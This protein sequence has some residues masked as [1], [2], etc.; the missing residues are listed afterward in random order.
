[1]KERAQ[2]TSRWRFLMPAVVLGLLGGH[3]L[4][5]MTAITLATGDR[6]FAVVPDYYQKAVDFDERKAALQASATLGWR[7]EVLPGQAVDAIGQREV[8]VILRGLDGEA[9]TEA[10]VSVSGYHFARASDPVAFTC[11]EVLPG[12]YVGQARVG[13]EGF[14]QFEV[15]ARLGGQ[16]FASSFKQ[17]VPGVEGSR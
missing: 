11:E 12:Q 16:R 17:F 15:D 2:R 8:V 3:V 13:R 10:Q 9:I 5:V 14:W 1:M 7:A 4:F 6:S